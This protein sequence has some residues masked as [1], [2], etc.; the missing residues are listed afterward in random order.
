MTVVTGDDPPLSPPAGRLRRV[1]AA[2]PTVMPIVAFLLSLATLADVRAR[3]ST[4]GVIASVVGVASLGL[5]P[6]RTLLAW[7]VCIAAALAVSLFDRPGP[8]LT[9]PWSAGH[10]IA[11]LAILVAVGFRHDLAVLL[12]VGASTA[13]L[14]LLFVA[15]GNGP[16]MVLLVAV[17]LAVPY[18]VSRRASA[19]R[20]LAQEEERSALLTERARIAREL[21]D[22]VAHHMSMIAVR[23]ETAPYRLAGAQLPEPVRTEFAE[24]AVAARRS[25]TET[26]RL[27][28]VLRSEA[29]DTAPTAPQPGLD[30]LP[31]L[32]ESAR[33][34]GAVVTLE[35]EGD[36]TGLPAGVDVSAYR[37]VQE[38]LSNVA[39]HAAG[40]PVRVVVC[41]DGDR[42]EIRVVNGPGRPGPA[43]G[44]AGHG[45]R[46]M[47][48]RVSM[49]EGQLIATP[50][51]D[52]GFEV[53]ALLPTTPGPATSGPAGA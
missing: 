49:L 14:F 6:R 25:L 2:L 43:G 24:I 36:L 48:E 1:R 52:G 53:H 42:L 20:R 8:W 26:R 16:G 7:R 9:F 33:D 11:L 37:I 44:G 23:A 13:L 3:M 21:H 10:L 19:Q 34:A 39:R 46:G 38:A 32:A 51:G 50:T 15:P 45:L 35:T 29:D 27:L 22:V 18:L 40:A 17:L 41:R 12:W 4:A 5:L 28:G 47:R 30:D 31:A